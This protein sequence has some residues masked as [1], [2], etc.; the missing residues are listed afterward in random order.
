MGLMY[1]LEEV[2]A[3]FESWRANRLSKN[4]EIPERLW[5]MVRRL[6][7]HYKRSH[8]QRSLRISGSHFKNNCLCENTSVNPSLT[9]G[10]A[11]A[12]IAPESNDNNDDNCELILKGG[13]RSLHI[14]IA[15]R[16]LPQVLS[17]VGGYI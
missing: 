11:S 10:F 1:S 14:K 5:V 7:P 2:V 3:A 13:Q 16:Q 17:L 4:E 12:V 9:E 8:I 6:V 15:A